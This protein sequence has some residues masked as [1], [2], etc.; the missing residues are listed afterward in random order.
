MHL[1]RRQVQRPLEEVRCKLS[2]RPHPHRQE[3]DP[4]EEVRSGQCQGPRTIKAEKGGADPSVL[5]ASHIGRAILLSESI[6]RCGGP[7]PCDTAVGV[8]GM[9]PG[10]RCVGS[11]EA[12]EVCLRIS[13]L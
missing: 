5:S 12:K 2:H 6:G 4:E 7:V 9:R 10:G 3:V 13:G 1:R 11:V 8:G